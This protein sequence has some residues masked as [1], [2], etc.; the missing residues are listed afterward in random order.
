MNLH[1]IV[2]GNITAVN[3]HVA[4]QVQVSIGKTTLADGTP[5]PNFLPPVTVPGQVQAMTYS[6]IKQ[7]EGLNLNGTRRGI[8]LYGKVDGL[9]R[10]TNKGGDLITTLDGS[11]WIVAMVLEQWPDWCKVAV[12]LQDQVST[13]ADLTNPR[14]SGQSQ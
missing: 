7:V 14:N 9:V 2:A 10:A 3:P 1:S 4:V 11:V 12:T 8:Y 13:S 5:V 6:D